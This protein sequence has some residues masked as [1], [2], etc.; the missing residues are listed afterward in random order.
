MSSNGDNY[1]LDNAGKIMTAAGKPIHVVV[2][3]GFIDR[4]F[5]QTE[6]YPLGKFLQSDNPFWESQIEQINVTP[7]QELEIGSPSR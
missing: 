6:L 5:A 7:K 2:A 3:T 1:Y 4:K